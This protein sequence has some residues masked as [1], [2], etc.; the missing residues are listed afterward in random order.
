[1]IGTIIKYSLAA[2]AGAVIY[3]TCINMTDDEALEHIRTTIDAHLAL[4]RAKNMT[5][6]EVRAEMVS[7]IHSH[8]HEWDKSY[9]MAETGRQAQALYGVWV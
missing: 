9:I 7:F 8:R 6:D 3:A 2:F 4:T 5:D 1:M